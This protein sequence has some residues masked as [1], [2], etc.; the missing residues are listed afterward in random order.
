MSAQEKDPREDRLPLWARKALSRLRR[1]L[2]VAAFEKEQAAKSYPGTAVF[3]VDGMKD[4]PLPS[5]SRIRLQLRRPRGG[6]DRF[7]T[8]H[9]TDDDRVYVNAGR[10]V[11]IVPH[12]SNA[13]S[14]E[15][16]E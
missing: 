5:D 7:V 16:E 11:R 2:H 12:V 15:V 8:F 14:I 13:F 4:I 1:D 9:I 6:F 10:P 3:L